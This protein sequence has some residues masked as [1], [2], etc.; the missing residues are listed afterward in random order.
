LTTTNAGASWAPVT[1]STDGTFYGIA[2]TTPLLACAVGITASPAGS[3]IFV[4][5]NG[6][7]EWAAPTSAIP[8]STGL[9]AVA[10]P[11]LVTGFRGF[12]VGNAG[13]VLTTADGG[14]DAISASMTW[15][16]D[17]DSPIG[18]A[19][20]R[21]LSFP[22]PYEGYA[23]G[24][25]GTIMHYDTTAY[26]TT[27]PTSS[28]TTPSPTSSPTTPAP[29][30]PSPTTASPTTPSPT[31]HTP[32]HP[33]DTFAPSTAPSTPSPTTHAPTHPGDTFAPSIA[34]STAPTAA[35][36]SSG[37]L[38]GVI[39]A[40]I[41]IA[42]IIILAV[43]LAVIF[44]F[45]IYKKKF[46][47]PAQT[48]EPVNVPEMSNISMGTPAAHNPHAN[49]KADNDNQKSQAPAAPV[50]PKSPNSGLSSVHNA[51]H[52]A[53]ARRGAVSQSP[54]SDT[55]PPGGDGPHK[56]DAEGA[57]AADIDFVIDDQ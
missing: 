9:Y 14:D 8:V 40:V 16:K 20:F 46:E 24:K 52:N 30:T 54:G 51:I 6:G 55:P 15:V 50:S 38:S 19:D 49:S 34:P 35:D 26:P 44:Y 37:G 36:N 42:C 29:T 7:I 48:A 28:P 5:T 25:S 23:V 57:D 33:G 1:I 3:L 39:L 53:A 32:T 10:F 18:S 12:A 45:C 47:T 56:Q 22:F 13:V 21:A 27:T 17:V 11:N 4:T 43:I 2:A 31:T 41:I